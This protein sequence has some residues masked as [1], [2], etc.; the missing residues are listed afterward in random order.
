MFWHRECVFLLFPPQP[1]WWVLVFISL[2]SS[3]LPPASLPSFLSFAVYQSIIRSI[4]SQPPGLR[5]KIPHSRL[6]LQ[7]PCFSLG[8]PCILAI[9]GGS[10][11][12]FATLCLNALENSPQPPGPSESLL[13]LRFSSHFGHSRGVEPRLCNTDLVRA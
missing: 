2:S 3:F 9:R 8:F 4:A 13:F 7:N 5:L 12:G 6:A 11:L 1:R 10:N